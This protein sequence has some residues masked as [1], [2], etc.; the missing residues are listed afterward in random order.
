M[1]DL[2]QAAHRRPF[3][4]IERGKAHAAVRTGMRRTLT[5]LLD[6]VFPPVCVTCGGEISTGRNHLC[7]DC[8]GRIVRIGHPLCTICGRPF[9]TAG[10]A[11]HLCGACS[12]K[13]PPFAG[14][15]S[16]GVYGGVLL[17]TIH[18]FKYHHRTYLSSVLSGLVAQYE[19]GDFNPRRYDLM[20]GVPLHRRRLYERG[21][22]Q[23]MLLCR[24]IGRQ[25]G[26]E[27][28]ETG[29]ART[30]QTAPQIRLTPAERERNV[31]GAFAVTGAG[32]DGKRVL[33]VDDVYTTGATVSECSRVLMG[34]GAKEVGV[35]T[36]ARVVIL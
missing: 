33:L 7:D 8:L 2:P 13:K 15:R 17:D 36:V 35:L 14:A 25:W 4:F 9:L 6:L 28:V 19:W 16:F 3:S 24:G 29:L 30:R 34:A 10:D 27:V 12:N 21:F 23:A 26:M 5:A 18:L 1:A 31:R 22:N 32:F 20:V 11:D